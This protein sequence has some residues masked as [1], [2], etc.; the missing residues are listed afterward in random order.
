LHFNAPRTATAGLAGEHISRRKAHSVEFAD[1]RNYAPG[2]DFRLVD[3]NV[4][5][6]L[7][8][9]F[10]KLTEARE[11]LSLHILIDCSPSMDWGRP[12]KLLYAKRVAAALGAMALAGYDTVSLGAFSAQLTA[13]FP[14]LRG[15][16]AVAVLLE[17]LTTLQ[18]GSTTDLERSV[19][20][21]CGSV[22]RRGVAILLTDFLV[23]NG[24]AEALGYLARSGL[25]TTALHLIDRQ[26]Q[27]PDLTGLV[28]LRD[29]ETDELVK[30]AVTPHLLRRYDGQFKA[31]S[32]DIALACRAR[33]AH[34]VQVPTNVP[35]QTLVLRTLR[36]EGLLR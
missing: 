22:G 34:Y 21:Y 3:W 31:W 15:R 19:A 1:H 4:Y 27:H 11:N 30:V 18:A 2:D 17:H 26:E 8:E 24:H 32:D 29:S 7:G 35:P 12:N 6:R 33:R 25:Y 13:V 36:R 20:E 5:A 9:L 16:S 14:P 28:E 23:P 10:L